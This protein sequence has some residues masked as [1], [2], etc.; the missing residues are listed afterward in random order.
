MSRAEDYVGDNKKSS[1]AY[2]DYDKNWRGGVESFDAAVNLAVEGWEE[3]YREVEKMA[4]PLFDKISSLVE[5]PD[6][7]HDIEGDFVDIGRF[8]SQEPECWQK[9]QNVITEGQGQ[10]IVKIV[11]NQAASGGV[12][13]K[14]MREKGGMVVSLINLLEYAGFRTEI[15]LA[16]ATR[17]KNSGKFPNLQFKTLLK[18]PDMTL[19]GPRLTFALAHAASFRALGFAVIETFDKDVLDAMGMFPSVGNGT[20]GHIKESDQGDIYIEQSFY[21]K[22]Y[23][24]NGMREW[25]LKKLEKQGVKLTKV[26]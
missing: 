17:T 13:A 1:S 3:G 14:A 2:G 6:V 24:D 15:W 16:C 11:L 26:A 18:S 4:L 20:P 10:K 23:D 7:V 25:V 19:D 8:V 22:N 9:F 5:R 21:D 12:S